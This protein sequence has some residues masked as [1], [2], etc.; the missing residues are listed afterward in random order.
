M[1]S[2]KAWSGICDQQMF[3]D[4]LYGKREGSGHEGF[5]RQDRCHHR[6]RHGH[7]PR[8][9]ASAGRRRLQ[10]RDVR[11]VGAEHGRDQAALRRAGAAGH[12]CC[13][14]CRRRV[15]RDAGQRLG[16][17]RARANSTRITSICSSTMPASAA[18][19]ASSAAIARSG[20]RR[21]TSAGA[22]SITARARS[23]RC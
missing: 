13:D 2:K 21:S 7:G 18:A 10:C 17:R 4:A 20:R 3:C 19:A 8:T 22:A 1:T 16:Q 11:R 15:D 14:L 6:R 23:C 9:G 5:C 12:A